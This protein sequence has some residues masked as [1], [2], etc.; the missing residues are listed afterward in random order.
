[1]VRNPRIFDLRF[2]RT[3]SE[4]KYAFGFNLNLWMGLEWMH[5]LSSFYNGPKKVQLYC[6]NGDTNVG[7]SIL[8]D[9]FTLDDESLLYKATVGAVSDASGDTLGSPNLQR[10]CTYDRPCND[11]PNITMGGWW[12]V[13]NLEKN[14]LTHPATHLY[15][16]KNNIDF[17]AHSI[18]IAYQY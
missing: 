14:A 18:S 11:L 1:M 6:S 5:K 4:Y 13:T 9:S 10:F 3:W 8:Y 17:E 7:F 2:N 16:R 12:Y 15:C